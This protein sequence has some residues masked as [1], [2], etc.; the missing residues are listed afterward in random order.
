MFSTIL[1]WL[2]EPRKIELAYYWQYFNDTN[3]SQRERCIGQI[4][5]ER[6][7]SFHALQ[8]YHFPSSSTLS[9]QKLFESP[10]FEYLWRLHYIGM[11]GEIIG[12]WWGGMKERHREST[13]KGQVDQGGLGLPSE[14]RLP[15]KPQVR[16]TR[17]QRSGE[18]GEDAGGFTDAQC[19][20]PK[21][22]KVGLLSWSSG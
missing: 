16:T 7:R 2:T 19:L 22:I 18:K 9:I 6:T 11:I 12:H 20:Q 15:L 3:K 17:P 1:E 21:N 14:S 10:P 4:M 13:R 8:V 5:W